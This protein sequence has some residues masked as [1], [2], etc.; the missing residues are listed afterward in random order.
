MAAGAAA[1]SALPATPLPAAQA[2]LGLPSLPA[3]PASVAQA[4]LPAGRPDAGPQVG[5]DVA[6]APSAPASAPRLNLELARPRGGELSRQ[7]GT[8]VLALMPRPPEVPARLSRD[9]D[10]S[11]KADCRQAYQG[12]GVLAAVPLAVET[13]RGGTASGC[14]W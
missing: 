10:K 3:A 9:I 2:P 6:T 11:A 1:A 8:G 5:H 14:K 12:L 4:V 13:L 7:S